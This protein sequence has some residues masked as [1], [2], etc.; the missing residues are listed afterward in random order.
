[1][2]CPGELTPFPQLRVPGEGQSQQPGD[3]RHAGHDFEHLDHYQNLAVSA[4]HDA[5]H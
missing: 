5:T 3:R 4:N 1:M 2:H